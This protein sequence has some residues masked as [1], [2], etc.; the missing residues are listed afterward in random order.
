MPFDP[1]RQ[2]SIW[3]VNKNFHSAEAEKHSK[4]KLDKTNF[5]RIA[6]LSLYYIL[7]THS[8]QS[9]LKHLEQLS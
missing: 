9:N 7:H 1:G 2:G 8:Y 5:F 3:V 6:L 4:N